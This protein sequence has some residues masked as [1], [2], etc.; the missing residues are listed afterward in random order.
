M[1]DQKKG[2][3]D[4]LIAVPMAFAVYSSWMPSRFIIWPR[5]IIANASRGA[6]RYFNNDQAAMSNFWFFCYTLLI[7]EWCD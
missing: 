4:D 7:A 6:S 2:M 1:D 5:S 3:I